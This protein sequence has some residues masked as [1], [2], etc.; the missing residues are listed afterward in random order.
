M[1]KDSTKSTEASQ[2]RGEK[3]LRDFKRGKSVIRFKG[4]R[5]SKGGDNLKVIS[6]A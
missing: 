5:K 2:L 1:E 6:I 3:G 4:G